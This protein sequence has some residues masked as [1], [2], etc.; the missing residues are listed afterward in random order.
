MRSTLAA[1]LA[2]LAAAAVVVPLVRRRVGV[3][4]YVRE[5][6]IAEELSAVLDESLDDLRREAD[7]RRAVIAA[8][9]RME[10]ILAAE[11]LGRHTSEAPFEYLSRVLAELQASRT[12]TFA[13][14]E[15]YERAEF[16]THAVDEGM[17]REAI[18]ALT[19]L[20]NDLAPLAAT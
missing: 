7:P 17:R 15:L 2:A 8:Y 6:R 18:G 1:G 4:R 10:R 12:S 9:A 5:Q 19:A 3:R 14:T 16:S 20:R 13:L 11:G